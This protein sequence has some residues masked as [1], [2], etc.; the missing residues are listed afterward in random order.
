[1]WFVLFKA[2]FPEVRR[3][4]VFDQCQAPGAFYGLERDG[5]RLIFEL[6][7]WLVVCCV[8]LMRMVKTQAR[9]CLGREGASVML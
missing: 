8:L 3:K 1:M 9:G 5:A 4:A 6:D 2:T 7:F